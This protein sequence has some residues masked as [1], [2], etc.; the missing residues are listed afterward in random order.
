V[1]GKVR[2]FNRLALSS[3]RSR[4]VK[5][6]SINGEEDQIL[7][8]PSGLRKGSSLSSR[9]KKGGKTSGHGLFWPMPRGTVG[10]KESSSGGGEGGLG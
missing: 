6:C 7:F 1:D 10:E 4:H 8:L 3:H 2:L 9:K 5:G